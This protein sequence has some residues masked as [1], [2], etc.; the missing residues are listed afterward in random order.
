MHSEA[1]G[2]AT[3]NV[4]E[5]RAVVTALEHCRALGSEDRVL[6]LSWTVS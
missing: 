2:K 4:A 5:Y 1:I 3:N 6:P